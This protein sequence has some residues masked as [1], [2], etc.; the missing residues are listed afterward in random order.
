MGEPTA[1]L[2]YLNHHLGISLQVMKIGAHP[3]NTYPNRS[4]H[5]STFDYKLM[6]KDLQSGSCWSTALSCL[7]W[8]AWEFR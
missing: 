4:D 2:L 1:G 6:M 7:L 5:R 8:N 3:L